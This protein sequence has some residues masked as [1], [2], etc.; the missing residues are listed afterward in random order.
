MK[1]KLCGNIKQRLIYRVVTGENYYYCS[2]CCMF[3]SLEANDFWMD[4]IICD[5]CNMEFDNVDSLLIHKIDAHGDNPK[6][7]DI[8]DYG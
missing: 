1:C 4:I 6:L 7:G 3:F 5:T 8:M 2:K